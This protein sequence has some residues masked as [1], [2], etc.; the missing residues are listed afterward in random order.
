MTR[1]INETEIRVCGLQRTGNHAVIN[2]IG[3]QYP[4]EKV[5]FLNCVKPGKNPYITASDQESSQTIIFN[6]YKIDRTAES[7]GNLSEKDCLIYS[8]EDEELSDIFNY[9]YNE[10]IGES[11]DIKNVLILRDPF[12]LFASRLKREIAN[13]PGNKISIHD[14]KENLV[15][16]WKSYALEYL[17]KSNVIKSN[18]VV[19]NFNKWAVSREY[20]ISLA[21]QLNI[22]FTDKGFNDVTSVGGGSSFDKNNIDFDT[23]KRKKKKFLQIDFYRDLL[24]KGKIFSYGK[25]FLMQP[26]KAKDLKIGERWKV[27]KDNSL[28]RSLFEDKELIQ[29]T[30]AIFDKV[31]DD[32]FW[33]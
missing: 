11:K 25:R 7:G 33:S 8:F 12:N 9:N 16:L 26:I 21:Q 24:L 10:H 5:L 20:R 3:Q 31:I 17:D 2:W 14:D 6:Q 4:K 27:F 13:G 22:P 18:K 30:E 23:I 32:D 28:Y 1:Y 15:N 19:V 29:L